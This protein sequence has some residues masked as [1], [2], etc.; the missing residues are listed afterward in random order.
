MMDRQAYPS[1]S[2]SN[3]MVHRDSVSCINKHQKL[4]LNKVSFR[5]SPERQC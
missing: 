1:D 4:L 3:V 2:G 5:G